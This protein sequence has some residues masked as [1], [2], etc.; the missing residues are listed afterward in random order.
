MRKAFA[1]FW[2]LLLLGFLSSQA[3]A[4]I[5]DL[6]CI[7]VGGNGCTPSP[8]FGFIQLTDDG[9]KVD[10]SVTLFGP[11]G[12][13]VNPRKINEIQLNYDDALFSDAS[14]FSTTS[15]TPVDVKENDTKADGYALGRLD[16]SWK[17]TAF[18]V[19]ND[20]LLLDAGGTNLDPAH[21]LFKDTANLI[22]AAV[23]IG[24]FPSTAGSIWVGS[25]NEVAVPPVEVVIPEPS[26]MILLGSGLL[27]A[28]AAGRRKF[29]KK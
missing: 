19:Y 6:D 23:H 16:L 28:A 17:P 22:F 7:I 4:I 29:R 15:G 20:E 14:A 21:F 9:N 11:G 12:D 18:S 24:N 8:S 26:T 10:V 13:G 3:Q 2:V 1:I 25:L 27:M 5:F